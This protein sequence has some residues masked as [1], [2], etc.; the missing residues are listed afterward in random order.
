MLHV[1]TVP[2]DKYCTSTFG[3]RHFCEILRVFICTKIQYFSIFVIR[4][5]QLVL[6]AYNHEQYSSDLTDPKDNV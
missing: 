4:E 1:F 3:K 5:F 6:G 2:C